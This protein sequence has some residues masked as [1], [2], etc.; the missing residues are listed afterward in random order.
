MNGGNEQHID[1]RGWLVFFGVAEMLLGALFLAAAAVLLAGGPPPGEFAEGS[2]P[3]AYFS[4]FYLILAGFFI[5]MGIGSA[6]VRQ[7]ARTVMTAASW[8]WLI[9]GTLAFFGAAVLLPRAL[10]EFFPPGGVE[11][12][13]VM[14][15]VV[16][17]AFLFLVAAP[18]ALVL[19]YSG[20]H[21]K[22]TF[23]RRHPGGGWTERCPMPPFSL[24]LFMCF[25]GVVVLLYM[26][27]PMPFPLFGGSVSGP[28]GTLLWVVFG[29]AMIYAGYRAYRVHGAGWLLSAGLIGFVLLSSLVTF[30]FG[31]AGALYGAVGGAP[32]RE[33]A[34][35]SL[36]RDLFL[37]V[38]GSMLLFYACYFAWLRKFFPKPLF[39]RAS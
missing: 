14:G 28:G 23:T 20:K 17:F 4:A 21:V 35:E 3:T 32:G 16:V 5:A 37:W 39:P 11:Y 15:T 12:Q 24:F 29:L 1:R 19:F 34:S 33:M 27:M 25:Q 36:Y 31:D 7:W 13:A 22:A 2:F 18:L 30:L 6:A 26:L 38:T 10:P 9:T 8:F